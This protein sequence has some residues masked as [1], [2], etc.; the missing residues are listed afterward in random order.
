MLI[1]VQSAIE[2]NAT[3]VWIFAENHPK[4]LF[5]LI[6]P[7]PYKKGRLSGSNYYHICPNWLTDKQAGKVHRICI[8]R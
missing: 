5:V 7:F 6:A 1:T 4:S 8:R 3:V 2:R